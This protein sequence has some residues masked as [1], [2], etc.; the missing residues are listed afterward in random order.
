CI[1]CVQSLE[2]HV[3]LR[4]RGYDHAR[5]D[6]LL[7]HSDNDRYHQVHRLHHSAP[8]V[9]T[10]PGPAGF[11]VRRRTNT[12]RW[13]NPWLIDCTSSRSP[14]EGSCAICAR[15]SSRSSSKLFSLTSRAAGES[16]MSRVVQ[17]RSRAWTENCAVGTPARVSARK[18]VSSASVR[19][20]YWAAAS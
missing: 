3:R 8:C 9:R 20:R 5:H 15:T 10:G 12:L 1:Q 4:Q 6:E 7:L 16:S 19:E 17:S 11:A 13:S 18:P 2:R 14:R